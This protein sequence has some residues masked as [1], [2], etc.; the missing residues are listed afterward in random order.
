MRKIYSLFIAL[1]LTTAITAQEDTTKTKELAEVVITGQYQP[2]SVKNSVYQ[3]RTINN[4]RIRLS[5][6]TTLQQVMTNQLGFRFFND[7]TLGTTDLN[8][9]GMSGRNVKIL[10]DG[11]PLTDRNDARESLGQVDINTV[12][13]IEIVE[14][15]MSVSYGSDALAGV[16][17][18]ITKKNT[19]DDL[20]VSARVQEET[21]GNE[22][23]P[24]SYKGIHN[25]NINIGWKKKNWNFSI[26]GTH[27]EF[28]GFGGDDFGRAKTWRPKE[29]WMGNIKLGYSKNAFNVYYRLDGLNE[30]ITDR[31]AI[32]YQVFRALDKK[33]VTDRY[34]HQ[35]Q[36][37]WQINTRLNLNTVLSFTDYKRKTTTSIHDFEKN[38]DE[39]TTGDGEQ[40]LS[41]LN[42]FL[43]RQTAQYDAAKWLSVQPGI[44]IE[45]EAAGGARI[46]GSPV[47]TSYALFASGEIKPSAKINIRPG[48]RFMHNSVYDAPPVIP[49]LNTKFVLS[50]TL[51]LRLAYAYGFRSPELRELYFIFSDANHNIFGNPGLKAEH[52]NS[53]TGSL[54]YSPLQAA[55]TR[56]TSTLSAFYN[57]YNDQIS[58]AVDANDPTRYS[59]FNIDKTKT[60]GATLENKLL[61]KRMSATLGVS[62]IGSYSGVYDD[63]TIVKEDD[64]D[65]LWTPELNSNIT[66]AFPK[67]RTTLGFFYKYTGKKPSFAFGA[68]QSG[69]QVIYVTETASFHLA[70]L[71][72]TTALNRF[73]T[74]NAGVKNLF[75]VTLVNNSSAGGTHNAGGPLP[76]SYGR[77]YFLGLNF[78]WN[79]K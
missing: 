75:D 63:E 70:D 59:Y 31:G 79:K 32:N 30:T 44:E 40:D 18:I 5:G 16:V 1:S 37:G 62:Y 77:S 49:S 69:Q 73:I 48:L 20:T 24:F 58:L 22:Y 25:Q 39:L 72:A 61:W 57:I 42:S 64:R 26:G 7:N 76:V 67:L 56:L 45:R 17:N 50:K 8:L 34:I 13:R 65:F 53:F 19:K 41:K 15:P 12:E 47:I 23:Y 10:L 74:V 9:M 27:N 78:Q 11:V 38:A 60:A 36:S 54:S 3:V 33:Y 21:A 14:G 2:Q 35:V 46:A 6:A 43:F 29:Q 52:S 66:Y 55:N 51:D 4:E 71:T 68:N 28:D